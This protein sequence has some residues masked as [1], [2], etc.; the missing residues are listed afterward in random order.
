MPRRRWWPRR[1]AE[2]SALA[3]GLLALAGPRRAFEAQA[4]TVVVWVDRSAS[5][6]LPYGDGRTRLQAGREQLERF[7]PDTVL[8]RYADAGD[9]AAA[10]SSEWPA[11]WDEAPAPNR[12]EPDWSVLNQDGA[13]WLTDSVPATLPG[14]AAWLA[15]GGAAVPGPV[16]GEAGGVRV[17]L[18]GER[19]EVREEGQPCLRTAGTWPRAWRDLID[20][21]AADRGLVACE[22]EETPALELLGTA[23]GSQRSVLAR[24]GYELPIEWH[25]GAMPPAGALGSWSEAQGRVVLAWGPGW[26]WTCVT[27]IGA[28]QG[29]AGSF[30]EDLLQVADGGLARAPRVGFLR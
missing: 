17:W 10:P 3:L 26:I 11:Q 23:A 29:S 6:Y 16:S 8:V 14:R 30:A 19:F 9:A 13:V 12:P 25:V 4:R 2:W 15:T 5:M 20:A 22:G 24:S 18:G 27:D 28:W 7:L 1:L 21:W